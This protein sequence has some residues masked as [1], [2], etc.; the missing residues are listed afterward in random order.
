ML[1][2]IS[3]NMEISK[4]INLYSVLLKKNSVH[5]LNSIGYDDNRRELPN[6][7]FDRY[8]TC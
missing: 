8:K 5:K 3:A 1:S 4:Q 2:Y 6:F 7:I